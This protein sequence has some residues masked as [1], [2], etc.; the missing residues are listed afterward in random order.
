M[1]RMY[2]SP[3]KMRTLSRVIQTLAEPY[4]E[5]QV[6]ELVGHQLL[7]LLDAD[8]YASYVWND[9]L[10]RFAGRVALHMDD[11]NLGCYENY[12]QF[13]DPITPQMQ[14]MRIPVLVEE[15]MPQA[16]LI[17]TEF[18]N[19]F[20]ARDGL[21][22]GVNMYAWE[23]HRSLGD[24]RI[25]RNRRRERFDNDTLEL[26]NL[27]KPAFG[28]ALSRARNSGL[29]I[30]SQTMVVA[31]DVFSNPA[32][33]GEARALEVLSARELEVASL[34]ALGHSDKEIARHLDIAFTTVRTHLGHAFRKLGVDNR[35]Q[36]ATRLENRHRRTA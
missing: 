18:F 25:W 36:L 8:Y 35:V 3:A 14:T 16:E 10:Q 2:L 28:A 12:Y 17:R 13:R 4:G 27:I 23:G 6:R 30:D 11:A 9:S 29:A 33:N 7:E 1:A 22:W 31:G 5:A 19:D 15:I 20:L 34:A 24:L 26:L 21:Y 32:G